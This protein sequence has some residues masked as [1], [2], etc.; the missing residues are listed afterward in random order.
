MRTG[1]KL[2]FDN[3][4]KYA[5]IAVLIVFF[6]TG[7]Y[8]NLS[9]VKANQRVTVAVYNIEC[10]T[11][12][13]R[14]KLWAKLPELTRQEV[15]ELYVDDLNHIPNQTYATDILL[16]QV[17]QSDLVIMPESLLKELDVSVCFSAIPEMLQA[18][19][20][21]LS[22]GV[23]YGIRIVPTS[24]FI[25]YCNTDEPCYLLV[26]GSSANLGGLLNKGEAKDDAA[27]RILEYLLEEIGQ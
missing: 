3:I 12:V 2:L 23:Q 9:Q 21:Y 20:G 6:W 22:E 25:S 16:A 24:R 4:W 27:I 18:D 10:D 19:G 17:L 7:I 15:L 1:K 13:L 14:D 5:L 8:E 11:Q 26:N